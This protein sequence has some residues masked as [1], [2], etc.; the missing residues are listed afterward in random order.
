MTTTGTVP[1]DVYAAVAE[2][3]VSVTGVSEA[4]T[5]PNLRIR[6]LGILDSLGIVSLI[7]ALCERFELNIAP[8]EIEEADVASPAAIAEF[9]QKKL[10]AKTH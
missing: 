6:E 9:V 10:A 5:V 7:V 4:G 3:L 8:A 2:I 1:H